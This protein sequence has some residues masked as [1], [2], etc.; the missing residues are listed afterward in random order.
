MRSQKKVFMIDSSD[1]ILVIEKVLYADQAVT[2][3][4][5]IQVIV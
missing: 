1:I 4:Q 5:L 3:S 2:L